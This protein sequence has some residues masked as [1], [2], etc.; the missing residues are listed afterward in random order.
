MTPR[1]GMYQYQNLPISTLRERWCRAEEL[2][3]DTLW[4]V[5]TAVDPDEPRS[6]MLDGPSILV[7]MAL[8]TTTI[9]IG[10]LVTSLYFRHPVMAAR[11]AVTVDQLSGGRLE[12]A[13]GVGDPAAGPAAGG[14]PDWPTGER[15][16]RFAE[17]VELTDRLLTSPL[18]TYV[19]TYYQCRDT[20]MI[21]GSVQVPRPPLTI[22]A[23]GPRMLAIAAG[24]ADIWSSWGGYGIE[25]ETEF[26]RLTAERSHRFDD[27]CGQRGRDPTAIRH[28]IVC[29]PPLT[30][31]ESVD[32]FEQMVGEYGEI[33]IDEFVLYWPRRWRDQP[34]EDAVFERVASS[35][36]PGIRMSAL[37]S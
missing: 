25:T 27:L 29:F 32:Y 33:G 24:W 31:W 20:E 9:R 2:G 14:A 15:V 36:L 21:P 18:T 28:S 10:T 17:F 16:A 11:A 4:N 19:G 3:F 13:L 8:E 26:R 22:G 1:F 6:M 5:D 12:V 35:V 30:P 23:H 34:Q 37:R 7:A